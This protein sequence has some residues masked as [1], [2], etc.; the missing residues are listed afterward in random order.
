MERAKSIPDGPPK[1]IKRPAG[2]SPEELRKAM[3]KVCAGAG[4]D[5][6]VKAA[7]HRILFRAGW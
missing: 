6:F 2:H 5:D 3:D 7:A 4:K 1:G